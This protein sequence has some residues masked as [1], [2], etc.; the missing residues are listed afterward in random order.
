V[1]K[2]FQSDIS[3]VLHPLPK[4]PIMVCYWLPEENLESSLNV[5]F[6]ETADV[7]LNI[8]SIFTLGTGLAQMFQK[9]ALKYGYPQATTSV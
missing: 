4:I 3:V 8:G 7:N 1:D 5:F 2:Q 9:L 6:D